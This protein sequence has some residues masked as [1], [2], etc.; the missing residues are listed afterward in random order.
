MVAASQPGM[1]SFLVLLAAPGT[2]AWDYYVHDLK[3]QWKYK[4]IYGNFNYQDSIDADIQNQKPLFEIVN[5][6]E[7]YDSAENILPLSSLL[8]FL[9]NMGIYLL[10]QLHGHLFIT[11]VFH[12]VIYNRL[13]LRHFTLANICQKLNVLFWLLMVR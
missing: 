4:G 1:V 8:R 7:S 3:W 2:E 10:M 6:Y 11:I 13:Q 9:K 5:K 12:G